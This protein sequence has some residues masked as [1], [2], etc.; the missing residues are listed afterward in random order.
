MAR[1]IHCPPVGL[2][3]PGGPERVMAAIKNLGRVTEEMADYFTQLWDDGAMTFRLTDNED[4]EA[5]RLIQA[6]RDAQ[7]EYFRALAGYPAAVNEVLG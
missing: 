7:Q 3:V 1:E 4:H 5:R 2:T 6:R